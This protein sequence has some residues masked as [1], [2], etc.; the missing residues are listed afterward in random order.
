MPVSRFGRGGAEIC[1]LRLWSDL[2]RVWGS[3]QRRAA[4]DR[5][6]LA[7]LLSTVPQ[8][9]WEERGCAGRGDGSVSPRFMD[10]LVGFPAAVQHLRK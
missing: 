5:S 7:L 1:C 9:L 4:A 3:L 8:K 10:Q 2:G 6:L